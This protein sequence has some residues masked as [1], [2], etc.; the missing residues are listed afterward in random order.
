METIIDFSSP[1]Q[2]PNDRCQLPAEK[3]AEIL[4]Q[5]FTS[6]FTQESPGPLPDKGPSPHPT[7]PDICISKEGIDKMLQNIKPYKAAGP[8][9][10]PATVLKE[11]S[12]EIASI[13]ELIYCRSIQ[14]GIVP[15]DWK[16]ANI[17]SIFKK[18]DK[19]K[20]SNCRPVSLTCILGKCMVHIIVSSTSTHLNTNIILNPLQHGFRKPLTCNSQLLSLSHDLASVPTETEMIVMDFSKAFDKVPHKR[21]LYKLEW[22]G[23]RGGTLDWIQCFLADRTQSVVLDGTCLFWDLFCQE[24]LRVRFWALSFFSSTITIYLM[25][26][27]TVQFACLQM[28]V[29]CID[30][31]LTRTTS[32]G[33]KWILTELQ[34]GRDLVDGI[35]RR[36]MFCNKGWSPLHLFAFNFAQLTLQANN[37]LC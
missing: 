33:S 15:S 22:Y 16:T 1:I 20:A 14:S 5:Q 36:Q 34:S 32:T 11:L 7:M 29:F 21:L 27:P 23:I 4:D 18:G 26:S 3:E 8:D 19:Q 10:L 24:Y 30:M 37:T 25:A 31:L 6:V 28:T 12:H 35:Q 2:R 13:L 17:A 9:S